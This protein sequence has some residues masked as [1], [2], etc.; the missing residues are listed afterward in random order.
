MK[1]IGKGMVMAVI[2]LVMGQAQADDGKAVYGSAC[3]VCHATGAM[4]APK[5]GDKAKW[6]VLLKKGMDVLYEN[7][8]KGFKAMPAKG[9]KPQLS[10]GEVKAAVDY[11]VSQ[12]K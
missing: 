7:S 5:T 9:G 4:A 1:M 10:D 11:M 3:A 2:M 6:A 12:S 8:I